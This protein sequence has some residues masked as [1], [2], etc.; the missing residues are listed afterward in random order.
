MNDNI[1]KGVKIPDCKHIPTD[2]KGYPGKVTTCALCGI[3]L[4]Y[5]NPVHGKKHMSKK[6]RRKAK[7]YKKSSEDYMAMHKKDLEGN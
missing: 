5:S 6:E 3:M 2:P 7:E 1:N 4:C